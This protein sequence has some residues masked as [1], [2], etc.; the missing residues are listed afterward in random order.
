MKTRKLLFPVLIML[1]ALMSCGTMM[2]QSTSGWEPWGPRVDEIIMPIIKHSDARGIALE[3]KN[4][5]VVSGLTSRQVDRLK[6]NRDLDI[7]MSPSSSAM[8]LTF[9][10]RRAPLDADPVRQAIAC[11]VDRD[12]IVRAI[13]DKSNDMLL[14]C[15]TIVPLWN[16]Y[17]N[18]DA[19]TF[20]YNPAK[21]RELLDRA[22]YTID[23][24]AKM[25]IDPN[26]GKPMRELKILTP[27]PDAS[28]TLAEIGKIIA[29]AAS[30]V[31]LPVK[32][33][34][35]SVTDMFH[36]VDAR[37]FD[38]YVFSC[39]FGNTPAYLA[40]F[41]HS[42]NS[43][44]SGLNASGISL[45]ELDA[46]LDAPDLVSARKAVMDAQA[47]LAD[48]Q[49]MVILYVKPQY[50]AFNKTMV[51]GYVS[52]PGYSAA[53]Y[54]NMWTPLNIRCI[55][56]KGKPTVGGILRWALDEEPKNLNPASPGNTWDRKV[57]SKV[58]DKLIATDPATLEDVPWM[59]EKWDI[60]TWEISAGEKGTVITFYI[61]KGIKW[62]DGT[63]FTADDVKFTIDYLRDNCVPRYLDLTHQ[64]DKIELLNK[65]T[66]KTYFNT[67]SCWQLYDINDLYFLPKHI[68]KDVKDWKSFQPWKEPHP[69][70]KGYT[71]L[72]G[73]GPFIFKE[74]KPGEFVR[75]A[76]NPNYWRLEPTE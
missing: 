30:Q 33:E 47:I 48:K 53:G 28:P 11:V 51:A 66:V 46:V 24:K 42:Q 68:W 19:A 1:L 71:K 72:V 15:S 8:H 75:L 62:S 60:D 16:P 13:F 54:D 50:D 56:R 12:A 9:N 5:A 38:M 34:P 67:L 70:I 45:P 6:A 18:R 31:G 39:T 73:L 57:L 7:V 69:S 37:D 74:Y 63:Q 44:E 27:S 64:I 26:T 40:D 76:K 21:A 3:R 36:K 61:R 17:H 59:A 43:G 20:P 22:G 32:H 23:P 41:F 49:P 55:D 25:R 14:P 35:M 4:V 58:Y 65:Y 2:A 10:M 52:A 29:D